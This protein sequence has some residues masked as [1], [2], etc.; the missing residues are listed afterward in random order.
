MA[1]QTHVAGNNMEEGIMRSKGF[2]SILLIICVMLT[3][4]NGIFTRLS[5]ADLNDGLIAYYPFNGNAN[6]K[7]GNE[8]HG[9][10]HRATLTED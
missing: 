1:D 2:I 8:N 10:V 7:S 4:I 6:D 3:I 5:F 9:I